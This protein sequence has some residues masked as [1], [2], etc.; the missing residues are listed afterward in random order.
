MST[1]IQLISPYCTLR[2][3]QLEAGNDSSDAALD[4]IA[5]INKASRWLDEYCSRDFLFHDHAATPL[6][7][8]DAWCAGNT[9]YLPWPVITLTEV[10]VG[11]VALAPEEYRVSRRPGSATAK[12]ERNGPWIVDPSNATALN[13]EKGL[14]MAPRVELVGTFGFAPATAK[15]TE[16]PSPDVPATI[17]QACA[18]IAAIRSGQVRREI[19][20][21]G[22]GRESVTVRSIPKAVLESIA[23]Y[24]IAVV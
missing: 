18:A 9:I 13:G 22:G 12:I 1:S 14:M 3:A 23:A 15:P 19:V 6:V 16:T 11:G 7:V 21:A 4:L 5:E 8:Q 2:D 17:Q 10:R 20:V 24:R